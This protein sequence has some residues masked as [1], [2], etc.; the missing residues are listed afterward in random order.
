MIGGDVRGTKPSMAASPAIDL[1]ESLEAL[2]KRARI[3]DK[4]YRKC[5]GQ[6]EDLGVGDAGDLL[7]VVALKGIDAAAVLASLG[8]LSLDDTPPGVAAGDQ[9]AG[10]AANASALDGMAVDGGFASADEQ[11]L[12]LQNGAGLLSQRRWYERCC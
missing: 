9:E 2:F 4:F 5:E 10:G 6:L 11:Q 8:S 1:G 7:E 12:R 3:A